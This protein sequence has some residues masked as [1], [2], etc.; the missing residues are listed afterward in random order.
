MRASGFWFSSSRATTGSPAV[1]GPGGRPE[2]PSVAGTGRD[3]GGG[4]ARTAEGDERARLVVTTMPPPVGATAAGGVAVAVPVQAPETRP[5]ARSRSMSSVTWAKLVVGLLLLVLLGYAFFKWG[6]PYLSEKVIM[7]IIQWE[8]KSFGRPVLAVV[9]ITS[10]ALFPVVLLPSGPPMWLTGIVFGYGIGFLIIMAG[11]TIGMSLP[12]W[13]GLLFRDRLNL[14]LEKKWPRQ[15]ALI[16]LAGQGSWFQ[17]FRVAALLRISPFPYPLFNYAVTV[18]EMKFIPYICGSVVGMVPDVFIN[19][20]S[21][22]LIRTLAE[23]N[24]HEHRM[25]TVEIVYNV[26]SVIVAIVFAIGFTVYARRAL[27]NME[28]SEAICTEPVGAPAGSTEFRDQLEG[29]STARSVPIDV[30]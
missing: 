28:R 12:Y 21:G 13:I 14:W 26:V 25:T 19:I 16:K 30:V 20:Y 29:C 5:W 18:T 7:P 2:A 24:Y 17:Q 9:I 8:A 11:V 4:P 3:G 27:D 1:P 23:L 10:L 6:V 22:R 15:I